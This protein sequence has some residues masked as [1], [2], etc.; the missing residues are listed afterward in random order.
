LHLS[1]KSF[2]QDWDLPSAYQHLNKSF[3][4]RPSV[5]YYQSM[6]SML[7]TEGKLQAAHNYIDIALQIDPFSTIS[8][9]L[10]GFLFYVQE[11]YQSA[12]QY[13]EKSLEVKP[14]AHVSLAELG[15]AFL[16]SGDHQRALSF[17]EELPVP[18]DDLLKIGGTTMVHAITSPEKASAG[19]RLLEKE[20][21]GPQMDRATILLILC[22]TLLGKNDQALELLARA[23]ELK[24][25]VVVY[26]Q[27]DPIL[28]PLR[29][30]P[31]FQ[32]LT[33]QIF[34]K[35]TLED[36]PTR[37]YKKALLP[38]G[39]ITEYKRQLTTLME[40]EKPYL[41]P[42]LSL[43]ELAVSLDLPPNHLS[44]LLNEGFAQN[45]A[46]F[47][48]SYRIAAF[49]AKVA[50]PNFQHLTLLGLAYESG[51]NSKTVFN[52]FFKKKTGMT[53]AAYRKQQ[54]R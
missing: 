43:R 44:Q 4:Q 20:L 15:Q 49:Q 35:Q 50:D 52:T 10:K 26:T 41:R 11:R 16:L 14:D 18:A 39:K 54:L 17:F 2:L 3:E 24:L 38:K 28:K 29:E 53:P 1:F 19:L 37:K 47:V 7:V 32:A 36:V 46:E 27:I 30:F 31:E 33:R 8:F 40:K 12:I 42:E 13:Y 25:P 34:G 6:T 5:E 9:H 51:F 21:E 48:N 23:I 45:F 22:Y